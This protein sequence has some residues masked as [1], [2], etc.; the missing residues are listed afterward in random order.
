MADLRR[1]FP[2]RSAV[3]CGSAAR[4]AQ[5][6]ASAAHSHRF[7]GLGARSHRLPVVRAF[8]SSGRLTASGALR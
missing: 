4:T 6:T 1:V 2:R 7:D 5:R 8:D 3:L